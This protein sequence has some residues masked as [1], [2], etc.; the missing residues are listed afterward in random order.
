MYNNYG[1]PYY[2][3]I[4]RPLEPQFN[5]S[6]QNIQPIQQNGLQVAKNT[7]Q[8]KVVDGIEV[9]RAT[10]I[11]M[12]GSTSYFPLADSSAIVTKQLQNDGTSKI[13]IYKPITEQNEET[14]YITLDDVKKYLNNY[15]ND[16]LDEIKEEIKELKKQ[17]KKKGE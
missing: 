2:N 9:V 4:Y 16:E 8:G 15:E 13:T 5:Q 14:K 1:N 12:D 3:P 17:I 6:Q 7:L 10:D 11:P